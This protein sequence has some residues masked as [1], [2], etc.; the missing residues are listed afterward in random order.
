[1]QWAPGLRPGTAKGVIF[2]TFEDKAG[3]VNVI[4]WRRIHERFRR[5]VISGKGEG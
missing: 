3:I 4:V 5:A 2:F 1:M